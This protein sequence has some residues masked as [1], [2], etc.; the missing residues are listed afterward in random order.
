MLISVFVGLLLICVLTGAGVL[1]SSL[2]YVSKIYATEQQYYRH[3]VGKT[4]EK[5]NQKD[6]A[7]QKDFNA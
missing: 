6:N 4:T 3:M 2:L 5:I 1:C 7:N